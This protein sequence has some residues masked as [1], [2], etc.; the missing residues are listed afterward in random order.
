[1]QILWPCFETPNYEVCATFRP[2]FGGITGTLS[3]SELQED[4]LPY[5]NVFFKLAQCQII[6][7]IVYTGRARNFKHD[8]S[9]CASRI[10]SIKSILDLY[11]KM[12]EEAQVI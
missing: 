6:T 3:T 5:E 4:I 7:D 11:M 10:R 12:D 8:S 2:K 1:M 9:L